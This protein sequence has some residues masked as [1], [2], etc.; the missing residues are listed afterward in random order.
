META[1]AITSTTAI[2]IE[3][4]EMFSALHTEHAFSDRFIEHMLSKSIRFEE[5]LIDQLFN[6]SEK[7]LA[8]ALLLLAQYER[9]TSN[10]FPQDIARNIGGNDWDDANASEFLHDQIQETRFHSQHWWSAPHQQFSTKRYSSRVISGGMR[11]YFT[12]P[13]QDG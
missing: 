8:R 9:P 12:Q 10:G 1:K 5:N 4:D 13:Q 7:R 6:S 3:R 11:H 2:A